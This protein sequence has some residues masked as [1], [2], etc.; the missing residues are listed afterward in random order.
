MGSR[1]SR[2]TSRTSSRLC[3]HA[4]CGSW[5]RERERERERERVCVCVCVCTSLC[6]LSKGQAG[7]ALQV[8]VVGID[9]GAEGAEG[10]A[11]EEVSLCALQ[12]RC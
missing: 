1:V 5:W 4:G 12:G 10:F 2:S 8:D 11:G 7:G 6:D 9:Q 3:Q